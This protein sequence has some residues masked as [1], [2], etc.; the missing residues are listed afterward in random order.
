VKWIEFKVISIGFRMVFEIFDFEFMIF[1]IVWIVEPWFWI[2][3]ISFFK[4][5]VWLIKTIDHLRFRLLKL[6]NILTFFHLVIRWNFAEL[7]SLAITPNFLLKIINVLTAPQPTI[8]SCLRLIQL[9]HLLPLF[10]LQLSQLLKKLHPLSIK[11]LSDF[12]LSIKQIPLSFIMVAS[13]SIWLRI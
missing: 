11:L 13:I 5:T 3:N 4:F 6:Q 10:I 7:L 12:F 8:I 1:L 2:E 9:L